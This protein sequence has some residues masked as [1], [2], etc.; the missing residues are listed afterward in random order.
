MDWYSIL[1]KIAAVAVLC[2]S[3]V[4]SSDTGNQAIMLY[5]ALV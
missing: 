1:V 4:Q 2:D 3:D 5:L